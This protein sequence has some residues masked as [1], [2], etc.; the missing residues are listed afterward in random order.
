MF[1]LVD[2]VGGRALPVGISKETLLQN[3]QAYGQ[4]RVLMTVVIE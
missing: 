1:D 2:D 4:P 3:S